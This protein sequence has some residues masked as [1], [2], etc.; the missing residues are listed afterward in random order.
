VA[1]SVRRLSLHAVLYK[2]YALDGEFFEIE[3]RV[4]R[5][6]YNSDITIKYAYRPDESTW[7]QR[8]KRIIVERLEAVFLRVTERHSEAAKRDQDA[9]IKTK[10]SRHTEARQ[11]SN[12]PLG[13]GTI[14]QARLGGRYRRSV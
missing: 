2:N 9:D 12:R 1:A 6:Q 5:C 4:I 13:D 11:R 14:A 10:I 3:G 8:F 7:P